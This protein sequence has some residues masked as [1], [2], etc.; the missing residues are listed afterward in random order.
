MKLDGYRHIV[1]IHRLFYRI[2]LGGFPGKIGRTENI[3][4]SQYP[5]NLLTSQNLIFNLFLCNTILV[6]IPQDFSFNFRDG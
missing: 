3:S 4:N 5:N 6:L 2:F 1:F